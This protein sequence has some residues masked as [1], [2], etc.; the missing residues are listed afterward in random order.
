AAQGVTMPDGTVLFAVAFKVAGGAGSVS[1]LALVD[2]ATEREVGVNFARGVFHSV[3]GQVVI[4]GSAALPPPSVKLSRGV[5]TQNE[6]SLPLTTVTGFRYILEFTDV[7]PSTN[8]TALP[9][10]T[11]DGTIKTL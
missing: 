6:F 11:G 2:T 9:A 1:P 4:A 8:W 5:Y 3:D 7:L 10:V